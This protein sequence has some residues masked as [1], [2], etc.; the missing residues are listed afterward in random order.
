MCAKTSEPETRDALYECP[1]A[2]DRNGVFRSCGLRV[3][4]T[5]TG[6]EGWDGVYHC[7]KMTRV[8]PAP[9]VEE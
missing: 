6:E 7:T 2:P 8:G 3:V 5:E 1:G 9:A 4:V